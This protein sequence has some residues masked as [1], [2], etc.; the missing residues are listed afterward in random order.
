M[1]EKGLW[2][3]EKIAC[4][5]DMLQLIIKRLVNRSPVEA[6]NHGARESKNDWGMSGDDELRVL[7]DHPD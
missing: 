4:Y 2:V 1:T 3:L 6:P 5:S 7:F